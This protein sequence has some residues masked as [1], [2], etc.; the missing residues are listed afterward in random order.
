MQKYENIFVVGDANQSIYSWR[1]ADYRNILNFEK[2]Y[3]DAKTVLLEENY[4]STNNILNG[5]NK[6]ETYGLSRS[7]ADNP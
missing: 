7:F 4:R 3:K 5:I 6:K 2:D 1:N